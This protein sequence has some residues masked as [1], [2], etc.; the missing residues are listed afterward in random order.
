[1][2]HKVGVVAVVGASGHTGRFVAAELERRGLNAIRIVRDAT[3]SGRSAGADARI[4]DASDPGA[5]DDAL[6]GAS[7]VINCAGPFID[8]AFP[9]IDAALRAHIPY[10]DVTAE[11]AVA[12]AIFRSRH[13]EALEAAVP[14]VPAAAFFGGLADLLVSVA[15]RGLANTEEIAIAVGLDSWQPTLGTRLTGQRNKAPRLVRQGGI[16]RP[17]ESPPPTGRWSYPD[18]LGTRDVQMLSFSEM[19][20]LGRYPNTRTIESWINVEPIRDILDPSTPSPQASDKTGRS[21]QQFVMD[22]VVKAGAEQRRATASGRD[23]YHANAPIIVEAAHRLLKGEG[24]GQA[25]V[26]ALSELFDA[27]D[28]LRSLAPALTFETS[29]IFRPLLER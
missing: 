14:V 11:Q 19:A 28:F 24:G 8:T 6:S 20:T 9:V 4:A 25:G 15:S 21:S 18:P 27:G 12:Y 23:I 2:A 10:L 22:V 17:I 1:M 3:R 29:R 26:R 13:E 7:I 5:L 16:L